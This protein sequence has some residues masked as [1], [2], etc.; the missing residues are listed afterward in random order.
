MDEVDISQGEMAGRTREPRTRREVVE[1]DLCGE[2][3]GPYRS[4][5]GS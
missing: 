5:Q 3:I 1:D 4:I 2:S